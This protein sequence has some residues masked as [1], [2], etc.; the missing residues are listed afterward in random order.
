MVNHIH[1]WIYW[2]YTHNHNIAIN[3]NTTL[4]MNPVR[5]SVGNQR[6]PRTRENGIAP[7][8]RTRNSSSFSASE[9]IQVSNQNWC[10]LACW[11][12][13]SKN[14]LDGVLTWST[15]TVHSTLLLG[16]IRYCYPSWVKSFGRA[17]RGTWVVQKV[18]IHRMVP[19]D[20]Q[21]AHLNPLLQPD[22]GCFLFIPW[23]ESIP[24]LNGMLQICG[25]N[26][27]D[28]LIMFPKSVGWARAY[29]ETPGDVFLLAGDPMAALAPNFQMLLTQKAVSTNW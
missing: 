18:R 25:F 1:V 28:S 7:W 17:P 27:F 26:F 10:P 4:H 13:I 11:Y 22:S 16:F 14:D 19:K 21:S 29:Q 3:V 6:T 23:K 5:I 20:E 15:Y 12:R 9:A 24:F 2:I 8:H